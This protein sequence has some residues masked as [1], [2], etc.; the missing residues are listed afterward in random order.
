MRALIR[1]LFHSPLNKIE[2]QGLSHGFEFTHE[3]GWNLLKDYLE[4]YGHQGLLGKRFKKAAIFCDKFFQE[5]ALLD[6]LL[7]FQF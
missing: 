6:R 4:F 1:R 2:K 5:I 3:L 7:R